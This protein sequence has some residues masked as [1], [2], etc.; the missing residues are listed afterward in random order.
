MTARGIDKKIEEGKL[1][2]SEIEPE[3]SEEMVVKEPLQEP[4][5]LVDLEDSEGAE[6]P[7]SERNIS[8]MQ[9]E[10]EVG[11]Y[12]V[13]EGGSGS[14]DSSFMQE[15]TKRLDIVIRFDS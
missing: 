2:E 13:E 12:P 11:T 3:A 1:K 14:L 10:L 8:Q 9:Q 6:L 7:S 5:F 15:E 4:V